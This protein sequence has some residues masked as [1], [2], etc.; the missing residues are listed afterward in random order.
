VSNDG[1]ARSVYLGPTGLITYDLTNALA[2]LGEIQIESTGEIKSLPAT[3][4][5]LSATDKNGKT[6]VFPAGSNIIVY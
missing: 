1:T 2:Y 4:F 5:S 6:I 3:K